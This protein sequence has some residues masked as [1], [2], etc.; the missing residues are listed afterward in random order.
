M[1]A[2]YSFFKAGEEIEARDLY[3][4]IVEELCSGFSNDTEKEDQKI[5]DEAE[6]FAWEIVHKQ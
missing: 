5:R 6:E 3:D 1:K 4:D 2:G